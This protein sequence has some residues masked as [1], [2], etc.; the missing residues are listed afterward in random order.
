VSGGVVRD[1]EAPYD[2]A[3]RRSPDGVWEAFVRE[4]NLV[5]RRAGAAAAER[6]LSRDGAPDDFY[7]HASITWSPDSRRVALFRVRP[8]ERRLVHYVNASPADQLQPVHF[9]V[10]YPKP[11][12]PIDHERPVV[13]EIENGRQT[14]IAD[15][16]F[17][18][19][20]RLGRLAWR[21]DGRTLTFEY[22]ERGH[23]RFRVIEVDAVTG[24][25][26]AVVDEQ[27]ETFFN[28][29]AATGELRSSGSYF[30]HDVDDGR[31]ILWMS[32][33]DGWRHL[34][35]YD[36]VTG[37]VKNQVTHGD[38]VVRGVLHVDET[39]R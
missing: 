32:E 13:F 2:P 19:P 39:Q 23:R 28:Y 17:P 31:E 12:D 18:N 1:L 27:T 3:P 6:V 10:L 15:D 38:F 21:R 29:P 34:Y 33:R 36:G 30:R 4:N 16:L 9:S 11:G 20:F 5:V 7:D 14:D 8:G 37:R 25:A 35:L 24:R 22:N 26:R